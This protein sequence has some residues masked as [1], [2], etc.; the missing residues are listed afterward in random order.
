MALNVYWAQEPSPLTYPEPIRLL[1]E[2]QDNK[3]TGADDPTFWRCPVVTSTLSNIF[4]L[5]SP[6]STGAS[7]SRSPDGSATVNSHGT[8]VDFRARHQQSVID[9]DSLMINNGGLLLFCK[10]EISVQWTSPYF[11]HALHLQ[12][13]ALVPGS[14]NIGAWFRPLQLEFLL[15]KGVHDFELLRNE[16]LAY[17]QFD[18]DK[19]VNMVEFRMTQSILNIAAEC[20]SSSDVAPRVPLEDRYAKFREERRDHLLTM[21]KDNSLY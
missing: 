16:P 18:T 9:R 14:M 6:V 1:T 21:I 8:V 3:P 13:G 10:E 20:V 11:S 7:I 4:T 12:Y 5:R 15:W 2:L 19:R 17:M